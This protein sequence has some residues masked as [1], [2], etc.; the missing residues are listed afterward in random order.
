MVATH[1]RDLVEHRERRLVVA[2]VVERL[3]EEEL[4]LLHVGGRVLR[5]AFDHALELHRRFRILLLLIQA[6]RVRERFGWWTLSWRCSRLRRSA[7]LR[8]LAAR[9]LLES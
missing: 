5:L 9:G 1:L 2:Q 3:A 6:Q 8:G 7:G 4:R